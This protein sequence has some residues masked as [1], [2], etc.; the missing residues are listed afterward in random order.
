MKCWT[1]AIVLTLAACSIDAPAE[2][3]LVSPSEGEMC[4][5]PVGTSCKPDDPYYAQLCEQACSPYLG[6]CPDYNS[7]ERAECDTYCPLD[8]CDSFCRPRVWHKC[9]YGAAAIVAPER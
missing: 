8:R 1:I 3:T 9:A 2:A 5:F 6:Q 4:G 7:F